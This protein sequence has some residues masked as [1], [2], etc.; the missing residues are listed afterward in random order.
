MTSTNTPEAMVISRVGNATYLLSSLLAKTT[1]TLEAEAASF[2]DLAMHSARRAVEESDRSEAEREI[3]LAV[4][5]DY[6]WRARLL[7]AVVKAR[8]PIPEKRVG[9]V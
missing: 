6:A 5:G 9:F 8:K 1:E 4:A 2:M 3:L 7:R